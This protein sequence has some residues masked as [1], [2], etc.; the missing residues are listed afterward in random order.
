[1]DFTV[2]DGDLTSDLARITLRVEESPNPPLPTDL[3]FTM[4]ENEKFA[5]S[6]AEARVIAKNHTT[7]PPSGGVVLEPVYAEITSF[8]TRGRLFQGIPTQMGAQMFQQDNPQP[9][10]RMWAS[11]VVNVS[12]FWYDETGDFDPSR[13]L[14]EPDLYAILRPL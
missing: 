10:F 1:M 6:I 5:I 7:L 14:G 3:N 4:A 11:E 8:P 13:M 12:S 2:T 9:Q